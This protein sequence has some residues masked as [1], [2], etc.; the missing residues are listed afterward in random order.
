MCRFL[1][2]LGPAITLDEL[3]LAPDHSLIVQSHSPR[4][5]RSA[6]LN[7]D[8][9][10]FAWYTAEA[11]EPAL[12]RST[13]PMWNDDNLPRMARHLRSSCV[14]ANI[15]SA[16]PGIG[17]ATANTQPFV[18]DR[19]AF[20]HNGYLR[21]FKR[22][23]ERPLRA[24]LSDEAYAAMHGTS[25]S[26]HVFAHL[27]DA[28]S[29]AGGESGHPLVDTVR[30]SIASLSKTLTDL[31]VPA[32]L[33]IALTD[34]TQVVAVRHAVSESAPTLYLIDR[35]DRGSVIASERT[36]PDDAWRPVAEGEVV[37]LVP[38]RPAEVCS[39]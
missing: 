30:T 35:P 21:D 9:F 2:Y 33:N 37:R 28:L 6:I 31:G 12:Y 7:A 38:G 23:C 36:F 18:H 13:M 39:L 5:M 32:L 34:G 22:S 15:R 8:G 20:T 26:E 29:L 10:G 24:A 16:T 11:P 27:L 1:A 14:L 19:Y 17:I 3:L 25:D 4:E